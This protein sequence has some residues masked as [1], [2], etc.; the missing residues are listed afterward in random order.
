MKL[1][2]KNDTIVA[3]ASPA[4]IGALGVIRHDGDSSAFPSP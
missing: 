4:G 2:D 1:F 3:L